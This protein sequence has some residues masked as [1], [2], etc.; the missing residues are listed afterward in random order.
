LVC[1]ERLRHLIGNTG[2]V[3]VRSRIVGIGPYAHVTGLSWLRR[4][5]HAHPCHSHSKLHCHPLRRRDHGNRFRHIRSYTAG[6]G[7]RDYPADAFHS[8]GRSRRRPRQPR[9]HCSSAPFR[10]ERQ[11]EEIY[12]YILN[13][14]FIK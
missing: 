2:S 4:G 8:T 3:A 11:L 12:V 9:S 1:P 13:I 5:D 7:H 14:I 10:P 6:P